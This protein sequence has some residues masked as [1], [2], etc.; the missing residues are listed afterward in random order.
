MDELMDFGRPARIELAVMIDRGHRELPISAGFV[1]RR[2]E[3]DKSDRVSVRLV[4]CGA[5]E[6]GV[7]IEPRGAR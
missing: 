2:A 6:D 3:T 1:G 5:E 4:E 7:Y